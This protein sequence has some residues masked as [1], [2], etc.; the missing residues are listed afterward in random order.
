MIIT[1]GKRIL[2]EI[3]GYSFARDCATPGGVTVTKRFGRGDLPETIDLPA[4]D[5]DRALFIAAYERVCAE[6]IEYRKVE[7]E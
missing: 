6:E 4:N 5:T 1:T 7:A 3:N 2:V